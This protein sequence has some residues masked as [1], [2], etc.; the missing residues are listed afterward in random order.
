AVNKLGEFVP[1][2]TP[3]GK[4]YILNRLIYFEDYFYYGLTDN[5][6]ITFTFE[7]E[8]GKTKVIKAKPVTSKNA[9]FTYISP[10]AQTPFTCYYLTKTNYEVIDVPETATLYLQYMRFIEMENYRLTDLFNDITNKLQSE[11]YST[12]VIDLRYNTGGRYNPIHQTLLAANKEELEKYNIAIVTTGRTA[13]ASCQ[14]INDI[15]S[16]FP[17]VKIFGE[18]TGQAVFNYTGT[19]PQ[20]LKKLNCTFEYP[21]QIDNVPK[22]VERSTD[23]SRGIIPD[24]EVLED[25]A[26]TLNGEDAIYKAIYEYYNK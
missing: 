16:T 12:I 19:W 13:S 22:L 25:F 4:K 11:T 1:S 20:V 6:K 24:V 18:E 14:F 3:A 10:K 26:S 2:E 7:L 5:G 8:D 21:T 23:T 15:L 17:H 9:I